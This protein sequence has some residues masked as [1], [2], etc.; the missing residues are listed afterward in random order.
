MSGITKA[1]GEQ[2]LN[3]NNF[4]DDSLLH[5][6]VS[7][8][9]LLVGGKLSKNGIEFFEAGALFLKFMCSCQHY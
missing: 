9:K 2:L 7:G 6:I 4:Y 3:S 1:K 8:F 5:H